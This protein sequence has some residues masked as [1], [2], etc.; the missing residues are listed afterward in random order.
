MLGKIE[1]NLLKRLEA[2]AY[3]NGERLWQPSDRITSEG[4]VN[5]GS[6]PSSFTN[7][8][9]NAYNLPQTMIMRVFDYFS[10]LEIVRLI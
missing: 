6:N 2:A 10:A 8:V 3:S 4:S 5:S 1:S 9:A 7:V